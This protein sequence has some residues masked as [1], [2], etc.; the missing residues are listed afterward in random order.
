MRYL[1]IEIE[2][3]MNWRKILLLNNGVSETAE[4]S[5]DL[6]GINPDMRELYITWHRFCN[7]KL[8]RTP[9]EHLFCAVARYLHEYRVDIDDIVPKGALDPI[10]PE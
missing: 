9:Q 4:Q 3:S 8:D 6:I 2:Q 5:A 1:Y 7:Y 10:I